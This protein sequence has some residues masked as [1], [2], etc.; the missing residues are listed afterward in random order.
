MVQEDQPHTCIADKTGWGNSSDVHISGTTDHLPIQVHLS[1][2]SQ[3]LHTAP[4]HLHNPAW[5]SPKLAS[6][7]HTLLKHCPCLWTFFFFSCYVTC[8]CILPICSFFILRFLLPSL[9]FCICSSQ[10]NTQRQQELWWSVRCECD[11]FFSFVCL[12]LCVC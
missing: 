12:F 4:D 3:T 11:F 2:L 8:F 7:Y 1:T 10:Q 5:I 6:I 9:L